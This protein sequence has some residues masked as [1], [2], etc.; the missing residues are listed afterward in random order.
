MIMQNANA[1]STVQAIV[2]VHIASSREMSTYEVFR[3]GFE[4]AGMEF[5]L[6]SLRA[7][8]NVAKEPEGIEA[9]AAVLAGFNDQELTDEIR[10]EAGIY[11]EEDGL[12]YMEDLPE[13]RKEW[14]IAKV[15]ADPPIHFKVSGVVLQDLGRKEDP[16]TGMVLCYG[17]RVW[18]WEDSNAQTVQGFDV[19][20]VREWLSGELNEDW[21]HEIAGALTAAEIAGEGIEF[22]TNNI[23]SIYPYYTWDLGEDGQLVNNSIVMKTVEKI[24][25]K[26]V[27]AY[28]E[29]IRTISQDFV[30]VEK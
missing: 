15:V 12:F 21:H 27:G 29:M 7:V 23:N 10:G 11:V 2:R 3:T 30:H 6:G 16:D 5:N 8:F 1:V 28:G 25:Q 17:K 26:E 22:N 9:I 24:Y 14:I 18:D 4:K 19:E 13:L 20:L